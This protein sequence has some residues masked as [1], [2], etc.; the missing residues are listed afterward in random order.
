MTPEMLKELERIAK[1]M[2]EALT[3]DEFGRMIDCHVYLTKQRDSLPYNELRKSLETLTT[4]LDFSLGDDDFGGF[5]LCWRDL[6]VIIFSYGGTPQYVYKEYAGNVSVELGGRGVRFVADDEAAYYAWKRRQEAKDSHK[7]LMCWAESGLES[8][9]ATHPF[10]LS[11]N[12]D[13]S[14]ASYL[15]LKSFEVAVKHAAELSKLRDGKSIVM[16][17]KFGN[18]VTV[19]SHKEQ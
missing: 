13:G 18:T 12:D 19:I 17:D 16:K 3:E 4:C 15:S 6:N 5:V 11:W 10:K 9:P 2:D 1:I 14:S 8:K 7:P